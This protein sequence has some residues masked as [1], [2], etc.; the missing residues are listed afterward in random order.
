M[1]YLQ[2]KSGKKFRRRISAKIAENKT[3]LTGRTKTYG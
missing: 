3:A 2:M 1:P